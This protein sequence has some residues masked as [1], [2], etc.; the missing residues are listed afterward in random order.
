MDGAYGCSSEACLSIP[1]STYHDTEPGFSRPVP[2]TS[3]AR[4][5]RTVTVYFKCLGFYATLRLR[6]EHGSLS[7]EVNAPL[8]W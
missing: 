1:T 4:Q 8:L 3:D 5:K 6:I 2:F 7:C